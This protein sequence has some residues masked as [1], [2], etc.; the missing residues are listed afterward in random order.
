MIF[1]N[2]ASVRLNGRWKHCMHGWRQL[3]LQGI[4]VIAWLAGFTAYAEEQAFERIEVFP[5]QIQLDFT[6]DQQ[7]IVVIAHRPDGRTLDVTE[8][9]TM[10]LTNPAI[11][12]FH[13]GMFTPIADGS[14]MLTITY[15]GHCADI[16][17]TISG[18][19]LEPPISFRTD[20]MPVFAR[21]GCNTGSCH[22]QHA[23]KMVS[24]CHFLGLILQETIN[25]SLANFQVDASTWAIRLAGFSYKKLLVVF[26]T[27]A[28]KDL[29]WRVLSQQHSCVGFQKV[30]P[31][32]P[33]LFRNLSGLISI[34]PKRFWTTLER[35][36]D[37]WRWPGLQMAQIGMSQI[38]AGTD[39]TTTP[40][41][42]FLPMAS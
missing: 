20:V 29:P 40:R 21:G 35:G 17:V 39:P 11:A 13:N 25:A 37:W 18:A 6:R 14:C 12:T 31:T 28:E 33:Q 41:R 3:F 32:T 4:P 22:A 16:P 34:H 9:S 5:S 24:A 26:R 1:H 30:L 38:C 36:N 10:S 15:A 27:L 19:T 7:S 42:R 23:V 8:T 2:S